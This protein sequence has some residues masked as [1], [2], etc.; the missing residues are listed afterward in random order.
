VG[1][2]ATGLICAFGFKEL[3][4]TATGR[5]AV[6]VVFV[7]ATTEG[8]DWTVTFFDIT[9]VLTVGMMGVKKFVLFPVTNEVGNIP[10]LEF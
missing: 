7:G 6:V 8:L 5:D 1:G 3:I 4:D 2:G 9:P 10:L